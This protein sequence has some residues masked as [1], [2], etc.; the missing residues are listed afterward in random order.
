M[1]A[2]TTGR[3]TYNNGI[4]EGSF[5]EGTQPEG[6]VH[7]RLKSTKDKISNTN[8][9]INEQKGVTHFYENLNT[10]EMKR[11]SEDEVDLTQ[12]KRLERVISEEQK[13]KCSE[14]HTGLHHTEDTKK[15]IS[16]HSNNNRPK[17]KKTIEEKY[18]SL[19]NFGVEINKKSNETK[20]KNGTLNSSKPEIE[21]YNKMCEIYGE[22]NVRRHYKSKEYPFYC[23]I[24]IIPLKKYIE[25]NFHWTH[26]GRPYVE[27]DD[28]CKKQLLEWQEKAKTSQYFKNAIETW[29]VRDVIKLNTLKEN[30]LNYEIIYN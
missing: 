28:F 8:H 4:K 20:R 25:L 16:E 27:D 5:F 6:W 26:G 15:K 14:S 29:T 2:T 22:N 9:K 19:H 24:Y 30:H 23:D 13:R 1:G 17:A 10:G 18:G 3:K 7:G 11:F 21:F 12:W